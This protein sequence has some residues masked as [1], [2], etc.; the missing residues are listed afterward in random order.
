MENFGERFPKEKKK[1]ERRVRE[2]IPSLE[3]FC[4]LFVSIFSSP[5]FQKEGGN[6]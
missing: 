5:S 3:N 1:L 2:N 4:R 6:L